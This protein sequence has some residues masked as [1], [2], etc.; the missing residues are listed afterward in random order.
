MKEKI[1][2]LGILMGIVLLSG[3]IFQGG[4]LNVAYGSNSTSNSSAG[5]TSNSTA[6]LTSFFSPSMIAHQP[7]GSANQSCALVAGQIS[8]ADSLTHA[9]CITANNGSNWACSGNVSIGNGTN[10]S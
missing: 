6:N 3:C 4:G 2:I 1:A 9:I 10:S 7:P 5:E 8:C